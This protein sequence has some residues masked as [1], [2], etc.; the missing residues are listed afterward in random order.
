MEPLTL[1]HVIHPGIVD[2]ASDLFV[3][4]PVTFA[5][6]ETAR[7]FAGDTVS[8]QVQAVL[9]HDEQGMRLPETFNRIP[10]LTRSIADLKT[11]KKIRKLAL[12]KDI[13]DAAYHVSEADYF[14][15]TNIDI[16]VQPNFYKTV[17]AMIGTGLDAFVINR[18]TIPGTYSSIA[19]I[20]LMYA[21]IG[22]PH[23]GYDCFIFKRA[24]YPKFKLGAVHVGSAG[25]GRALLA[26]LVAHAGRFKEF[27]DAHLTFH[28]GDACAWRSE[29][30]S[31][32]FRENWNEYLALF[33]QIEAA[34]GDFEPRLRAYL[35]DTGDSRFI[36]D[37]GLYFIKNGQCLP[38]GQS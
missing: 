23:N 28:L 5:T 26:N 16:A 8:I 6:M 10:R 15:Y 37:F 19:D 21:E 32:Y 27:R 22:A 2:P 20:P 17:A 25:I 24:L 1:A 4:Q 9:F 38:T 13:L 14:I 33:Q 34:R 31:D 30:Y 36:P 7:A 35:L 11:F 12:I 29:E 18:R 3:A